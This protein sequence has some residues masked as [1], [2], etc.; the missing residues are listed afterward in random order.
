MRVLHIVAGEKWTGI[1]AVVHDWTKALVEAG[2]EAQFAFAAGHNLEKRVLP[3]GWARPILSR[4]HGVAGA[5]RDLPELARTL[6]REPADVLHVHTSHDHYLAALARRRR[7]PRPLLVRTI[8]H[9]RH[10]RPDPILRRLFRSADA[11]AFANRDIARAFGREGP[12]HSPVVDTDVFA[13]GARPAFLPAIGGL[14]AG[15]FV[16]GTVGKLAA[17]RGHAEA[18]EAAAPLP[19]VTLLHVG[20][21][22]ER[23]ALVTRASTAGASARNL[24]AGYQDEPLPEFYRAMDAFLFTASGS[25]Q[26]QRAVLEAL[27]SGLPVA[28]LDVPG[29]RDFVTDGVEGFVATSVPELS[30]ALAKLSADAPLR[31]RMAEA[32]RRRALDFTASHFAAEAMRF[33]A[34]A[35]R[36]MA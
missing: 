23:P 17:G 24:W 19:G 3:R 13:P 26:G 14:P 12:I 6:D 31:A 9:A 32:A 8:H 7:T 29:V 20:H 21:G 36:R 16:V 18:I 15:Q 33:Y 34:S 27:A 30:R 2:L 25:Q 28:A 11:F 35:F 10:T 1:A 4:P 5:L 22:E